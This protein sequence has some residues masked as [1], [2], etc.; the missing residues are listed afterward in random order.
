MAIPDRAAIA[1]SP[2]EEQALLAV[3][4]R[5]YGAA[6]AFLRPG[7]GRSR[8]LNESSRRRLLVWLTSMV[9]RE[10]DGSRLDWRRGAGFRFEPVEAEQ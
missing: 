10:I 3:L 7:Y 9:G 8:Y 5:R 1:P 4:H 2:E 6:M